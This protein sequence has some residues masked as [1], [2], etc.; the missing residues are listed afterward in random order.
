MTQKKLS[1]LLLSVSVA[2]T[3][4]ACTT[5]QSHHS[6]ESSHKSSW[7][8]IGETAPEYWG[9]IHG[10][11]LCKAGL[12]QSP[13]D[14]SKVQVS[15]KSAPDIKYNISDMKA[16]DNGHT[17]VFTPTNKSNTAIIEGDTYE[18]KQFHYHTPS[19][20]QFSG[21]NYPAELHFV[22]ANS[23][24]NLAVIGVMLNPTSESNILNQIVDSSLIAAKSSKETI[25]KAVDLEALIPVNNTYYHYSGSL[26]TPPCSEKVSWYVSDKPLSVSPNEIKALVELYSNNNRPVQAI[27]EREVLQ[28]K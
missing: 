7:S 5:T 9:D 10:N 8:Y 15:N 11:E 14:I 21:I 23:A 20:H 4:S 19:E 26:T 25:A 17:I 12:E 28:V 22:H 13:I 1:T 3:I 27:A 16:V 24:G 18:L 2:L 6:T